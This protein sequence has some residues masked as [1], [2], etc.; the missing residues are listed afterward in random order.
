MTPILRVQNLSVN[1]DT[2]RALD[3]LSLD[4]SAGE[5]IGVIGPNGAG[6]TSFIK[7]LCGRVDFTGDIEIGGRALKRGTH[8]QD[9]IG[10]VPQDIGLYP[11]M[12]AQENL[13]VF[14]RIMGLDRAA[15][16]AAINT[17]LD[18]VDMRAHRGTRLGAM[19]G[20]MKRR[21]NVAAAI[22]HAPKLLILDEPTAGVDSPARD[23]VHRLA[24]NLAQSGMG[25]L[26]I[27]HEL[28]HAEAM[29]D[30]VL[31]L[32][33]GQALAFA[34]PPDILTQ[35]YGGAREIIVRF[36]VVPDRDMRGSMAPFAFSQGEMPTIWTAMTQASEVS[37]VSAFMAALKNADSTVRE[38]TVRRPGLSALMPVIE[39][40]GALPH[41]GPAAPP[42][43]KQAGATLC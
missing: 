12:T 34:S 32:A 22:M 23:A 31:I 26:L 41:M 27:T 38:I 13:D 4:V 24:R 40:S 35:C 36:S 3:A 25:V 14:A 42:S 7:S 30:K 19:S 6:K 16:A 17:A 21:I 15:R 5:V 8:R 1:Y 43:D 28:D 10:L 11:H 29:C 37:F 33:R 39:R 9:L 20:G 18:A 2:K